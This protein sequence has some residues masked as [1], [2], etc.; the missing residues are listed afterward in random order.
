[1]NF[2]STQVLINSLGLNISENKKYAFSAGLNWV[3]KDGVGQ[4]G[5]IF[6][7]AKYS[8]KVEKNLKEWRMKANYIWN[9]SFLLEMST[10]MS[11]QNFLLI[12]S[13]SNICNK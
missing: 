12:A 6:F 5:S 13:L 10:V 9:V 4:I 3:I 2:L 8:H 11:P 1:M 7:Q